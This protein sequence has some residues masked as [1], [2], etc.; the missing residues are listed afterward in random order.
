MAAPAVVPDKMDRGAENGLLSVSLLLCL[1]VT[2]CI[3]WVDEVKRVLRCDRRVV[4]LGDPHF[5]GVPTHR[6]WGPRAFG[7]H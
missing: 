5:R 1:L 7:T 2:E 6:G 4:Q 3:G